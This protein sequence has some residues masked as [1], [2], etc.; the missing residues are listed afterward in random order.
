V[1]LYA[2]SLSTVCPDCIITVSV[3]MR[4]DAQSDAAG[5]EPTPARAEPTWFRPSVGR[6]ASELPHSSFPRAHNLI[7][8]V[9]ECELE[10]SGSGLDGNDRPTF[11][12]SG[13]NR[14]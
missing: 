13:V 11:A 1:F 3:P 8:I 5:D 10:G 4:D 2:T 6:A 7:E 9:M 14:F 12:R